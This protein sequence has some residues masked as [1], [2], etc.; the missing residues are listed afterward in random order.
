MAKHSSHTPSPRRLTITHASPL[1]QQLDTEQQARGKFSTSISD[2][3][4]PPSGPPSLLHIK[5]LQPCGS[6][7]ISDTSHDGSPGRAERPPQCGR[8]EAGPEAAHHVPDGG[9]GLTLLGEADRLVAERR[10]RRECST[11][12]GPDQRD[13]PRG[14][15]PTGDD[16]ED[17]RADDVDRPC[18]PGERGGVHPLHDEV[19]EIAGGGAGRTADQHEQDGHRSTRCPAGGRRRRPPARAPACPQVRRGQGRPAGRDEG[20]RV[21]GVRRE[22]GGVA[23]EQAGAGEGRSRRWSGS[24]R[25]PASSAHRGRS[26]R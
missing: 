26:T 20:A 6:I 22:L 11:E 24:A 15:G 8:G 21:E 1:L 7:P 18:A 2:L 25:R 17:E 3:A 9:R 10:E 12:A 19:G 16:A 14:P 5:I 23:A 4:K 13:R